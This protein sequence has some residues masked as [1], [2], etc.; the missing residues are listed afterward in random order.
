MP[1]NQLASPNRTALFLLARNELRICKKSHFVDNYE[2]MLKIL[3]KVVS[4]VRE[5]REGLRRSIADLDTVSTVETWRS[6]SYI[7]HRY[8]RGKPLQTCTNSCNGLVHISMIIIMITYY[9]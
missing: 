2:E 5:N 1:A 4:H 7:C 3:E 6:E 8:L 9:S